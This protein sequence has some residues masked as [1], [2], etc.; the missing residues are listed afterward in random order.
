MES[1]VRVA[2]HSS[3]FPAQVRRDLLASLRERRVNHKFHYDSLKQTQ[4][5]LALHDAFSPAR[6]DPD[7][8]A[9]YDRSFA[10]VA[11]QLGGQV[12]HVIGLGCGGG[13]KDA[14]LITYFRKAGAPVSYTPVD[15][16]TAMVL[17]AHDTVAQVLGT[18]LCPPLVCDLATASDL[19]AVLEELV[20]SSVPRPNQV[21]AGHSVAAKRL[22]T[23]FGMIPNFEPAEILP[24]LSPVLRPGEPMLFSANLAPGPDYSAGMA[25][26]LHQYDNDLTRDWLLTF[27]LDLGVARED[28]LLHF[29]VEPGPAD[30]QLQRVVA[31]F[32][33]QKA[34]A[35]TVER[36]AFEFRTGDT[37][38]LFFSYRYTPSLVRAVLARY[39]LQVVQEWLAASGEEGV[40][41]VQ[42][43]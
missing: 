20:E 34:R 17:V 39:Q 1:L 38:R 26:I 22:L 32:S 14:R 40:F 16:S 31:Y 24:C 36:E 6:T 33:F 21:T 23:F 9:I 8:E 11:Q 30:T 35:L 3:Q 43:A 12:V 28:G 5:W 4:R 29:V 13:Q 42:P 2:I 19:P 10:A 15:V 27:L 37:I 25:R 41:L 18:T 7:C